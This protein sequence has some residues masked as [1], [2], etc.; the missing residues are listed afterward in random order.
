MRKLGWFTLPP[1]DTEV[2]GEV[3]YA[4]DIFD[5]QVWNKIVN[6]IQAGAITLVH[7]GTPRARWM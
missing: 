6:W 4:A 1:I 3:L 2:D 5:P 7:F